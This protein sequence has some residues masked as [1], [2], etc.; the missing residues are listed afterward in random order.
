MHAFNLF[1]GLSSLFDHLLCWIGC[2]DSVQS[3]T[4]VP[5]LNPDYLNTRL[6]SGQDIADETLLSIK[7]W[8][9]NSESS[10]ISIRRDLFQYSDLVTGHVDVTV[11]PF[12]CLAVDWRDSQS[13]HICL[14]RFYGHILLHLTKHPHHMK[15][16]L[17]HWGVMDVPLDEASVMGD[18][19]STNLFARGRL[20]SAFCSYP[21]RVIALSVQIKLGLW[22]RNGSE[23]MHQLLNYHS[24]PFIKYFKSIDVFLLQ[25]VLAANLQNALACGGKIRRLHVLTSEIIFSVKS[26]RERQFP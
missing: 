26:R 9:I 3:G 20:D 7:N 11:A 2:D 21:L 5:Q 16:L 18:D 24:P 25:C 17:N 15:T 10:I 4:Y 6:L 23:M 13:F 12:D 1:I 19:D 14:H 8:E 22:R